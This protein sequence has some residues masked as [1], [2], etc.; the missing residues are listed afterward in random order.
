MPAVEETPL[1]IERLYD[2]SVRNPLTAS[3]H[4]AD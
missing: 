3:E 4:G 1:V 2:D